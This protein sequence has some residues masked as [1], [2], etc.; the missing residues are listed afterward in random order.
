MEKESCKEGLVFDGRQCIEANLENIWSMK[1]SEINIKGGTY[2]SLTIG[3]KTH[4]EPKDVKL[5]GKIGDLRKIGKSFEIRS[6]TNPNLVVR[7]LE[8]D[9]KEKKAFLDAMMGEK[10]ILE[11]PFDKEVY[12]EE[13]FMD[14]GSY[15]IWIP[16]ITGGWG[17]LAT[18]YDS[19]NVVR[20]KRKK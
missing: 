3:D 14:R 11:L 10:D 8:F 7:H 1:N 18:E 5:I 20:P 12:Y 17:K 2:R 15:L 13:W 9:D 19:V 6:A 16:E 4:F